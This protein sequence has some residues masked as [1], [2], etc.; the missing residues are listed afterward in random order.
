[1]CQ[2][3]PGHVQGRRWQAQHEAALQAAGE[4]SHLICALNHDQ[5]E[6]REAH[7]VLSSDSDWMQTG[8][9]GHQFL[10]EQSHNLYFLLSAW[11]SIHFPSPSVPFIPHPVTPNQKFL[12][13]SGHC[14]YSTNAF[15]LTTSLSQL[16]PFPFTFPRK[17]KA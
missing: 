9:L 14:S 16:L 13:G 15:C 6:A 17:G 3:Q 11:I 12:L 5:R 10:T 2:T 7:M 4:W 8:L 1:M